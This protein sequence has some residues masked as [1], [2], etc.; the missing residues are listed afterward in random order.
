MAASAHRRRRFELILVK[1]SHYDDD[2]YVIQWVK[3]AVPSNA[4]A[5]LYGLG[6][7][8]AE[9]KVLGPDVEIV[10]TCYDETNTRIRPERLVRRIEQAGGH[11]LVALVGVQS[12]QF[13]R[14]MDISRPLREAGIQVCIGGFH[15][16][17]S[18]AMLDELPADLVEA[19]ALGVSLFAGEGEGRL[20]RVLLDAEQRALEPLYD[21]LDDLVD[22]T[23]AVP[24]ILQTDRIKRTIGQMSSFDAGRG[25]PFECSFCTIINVQGSRSRWRSRRHGRAIDSRERCAGLCTASSSRTIILPA[26]GDWEAILD[27]IILPCAKRWASQST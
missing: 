9:R 8:C 14:A 27:R 25:C 13:P 15:V 1:P 6:M 22:L 2:G 21:Y 3:S 16:S 24:P 26:I 23:S 7:N 10:V 11:G 12:N 17:G 20:Q 5:V 4:L 19:Q 18:I